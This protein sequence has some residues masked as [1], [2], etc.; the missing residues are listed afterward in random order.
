MDLHG[1]ATNQQQQICEDM[2]RYRTHNQRALANR[3]LGCP[4]DVDDLAEGESTIADGA[5]SQAR[6]LWLFRWHVDPGGTA[7]E[8]GKENPPCAMGHMYI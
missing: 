5:Q 1:I 3:H 6:R 8:H 7:K 2:W 4:I